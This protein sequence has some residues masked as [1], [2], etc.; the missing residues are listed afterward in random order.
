MINLDQIDPYDFE[1][2]VA[3]IW[4][5]QGWETS[6]T[7]SSQDRG[8][9]V[10]AKQ[11]NPIRLKILIQAKAYSLDNKIGSDEVRKYS[12]LYEQ[13]SQVDTVVIVTTGKFTSQATTLAEDLNVRLINRDQLLQLMKSLDA[14]SIVGAFSPVDTQKYKLDSVP[15]RSPNKSCPECES[16]NS[17]WEASLK[18]DSEILSCDQCD[19]TWESKYSGSWNLVE[20]PSNS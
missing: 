18:G 13:E 8:I 1:K 16:N 20:D 11:S 9:D 5:V 3:D 7:N 4:Q 6:V 12:T 19:A 2:L 17:L 10:I 15:I 14:V